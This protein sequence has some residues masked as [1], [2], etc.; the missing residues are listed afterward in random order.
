[1]PNHR[2]TFTMPAVLPNTYETADDPAVI[3]P[4]VSE[5]TAVWHIHDII[6]NDQ[7]PTLALRFRCKNCGAVFDGGIHIHGP[8]TD[9]V[10]GIHIQRVDKVFLGGAVIRRG[11]CI[12]E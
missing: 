11:H 4:A 9:D 12:E 8:A 6:N 3:C 1:M 7:C 2:K 10:S 5:I